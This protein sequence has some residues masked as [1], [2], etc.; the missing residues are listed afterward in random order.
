MAGKTTACDRRSIPTSDSCSCW[1]LLNPQLLFNNTPITSYSITN[2]YIL[3]QGPQDK[4]KP[5]LRPIYFQLCLRQLPLHNRLQTFI[6][7]LILQILPRIAYRI[8]QTHLLVYLQE[9][10][11][12]RAAKLPDQAHSYLNSLYNPFLSDFERTPN[13]PRLVRSAQLNRI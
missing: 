2:K 6:P 5:D 7:T 11:E 12:V 1:Q 9:I 8:S 13:R 4:S 10:Y 3:L